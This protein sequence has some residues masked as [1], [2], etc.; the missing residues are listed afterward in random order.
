MNAEEA[1][2]IVACDKLRLNNEQGWW[3]GKGY[4][5]A[6][7]GDDVKQMLREE[8]KRVLESEEVLALC[9]EAALAYHYLRD[10]NRRGLKSASGLKKAIEDFERIRGE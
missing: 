5:E 4:L 10:G 3:R 6:L 2:E 8:R 7:E 1:R 9:K